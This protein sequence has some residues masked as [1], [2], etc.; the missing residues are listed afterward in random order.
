MVKLVDYQARQSELEEIGNPFGLAVLAHLKT[1]ETKG[2]AE[3]RLAWKLRPARQLFDRHWTREQIE[4]LFQFLDWIMTL[5]EAFE[6]R[7]ETG[8]K[9]TAYPAQ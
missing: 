8:W 3:S 9:Q 4:E 2:D 6:D 5:P 1:Q 7:F